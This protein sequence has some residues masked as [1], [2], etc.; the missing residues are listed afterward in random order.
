[1]TPKKLKLFTLFLLLMPLCLVML[2]AGCE[3]EDEKGYVN[4][5]L[6]YTK[7]PCDSEMSF[8]EEVIISEILLFDTTKTTFTEMQG[9]S[10]N[11][12]SYQFVSYNPESNNAVFYSYAPLKVDIGYLCNFPE[13]ARNWKIPSGGIYISYSIDRFESCNAKSSAGFKYSYTDNILTSLKKYTK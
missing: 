5:P 7:C 12:D 13:A 1:M 10:S 11:G 3:K 4:I 6:E 2:G 8:I 9:L